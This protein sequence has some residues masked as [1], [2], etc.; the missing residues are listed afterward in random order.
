MILKCKSGEDGTVVYDAA[1]NG[2]N[3]TVINA[4]VK[5]KMVKTG[6]T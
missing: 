5:K 4:D 3:G 1:G 2:Y 6:L